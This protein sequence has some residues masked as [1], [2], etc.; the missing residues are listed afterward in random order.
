[1][2]GRRDPARRQIVLPLAGTRCTYF[3][4]VGQTLRWVGVHRTSLKYL[5]WLGPPL[6]LFENEITAILT[7][8]GNAIMDF[9]MLFLK[10]ILPVQF[11]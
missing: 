3:G 8:I 6:V 5:P 11:V 10:W 7:K 9:P 1:M 4:T 2:H